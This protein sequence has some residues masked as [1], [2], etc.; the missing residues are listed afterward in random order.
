MATKFSQLPLAGSLVGDETLVGLKPSGSESD[1]ENVLIS[2]DEIA[3]FVL[4]Q[5][6]NTGGGGSVD[7]SGVTFTPTT[8]ADWDGSTDPG[9]VDDALDQLAERVTDLEG[10]GGG[11]GDLVK[12]AE[13]VTSGSQA[14]VTFS[15]I[16][17]TYRNLKLIGSGRGSASAIASEVFVRFNG[18]TGSNYDYARWTRG[19]TNEQFAQT[20][21]V[22]GEFTAATSPSNAAGGIDILIHNYAGTTFNKLFSGNGGLFASTS[23]S[24]MA[25]N[26]MSGNWRST[27]AISSLSLTLASGNFLDNSVFTLYGIN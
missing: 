5:D 2:V 26:V 24:G 22:L 16:P 25:S 4:S 17:G 11:G 12:I 20:R 1:E 9:N 3:T 23:A 8:N 15:S 18:D 19:G 21:A 27:S 13:V 7:A 10:G 14:T 6:S